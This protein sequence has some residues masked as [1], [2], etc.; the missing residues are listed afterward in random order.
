LALAPAVRRACLTP[1]PPTPCQPPGNPGAPTPVL[2]AVGR[3]WAA[4]SGWPP[5]HHKVG[6]TADRTSKAFRGVRASLPLITTRFR[7]EGRSL[8]VCPRSVVIV[9]AGDRV[10]R[11]LSQLSS[12]GDRALRYLSR[13]SRGGA[14]R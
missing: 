6:R 1:P 13:V 9:G 8:L 12:F 10:L 4:G 11:S 2:W 3:G 5:G 7:P 14:V